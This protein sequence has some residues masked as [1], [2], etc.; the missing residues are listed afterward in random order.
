MR[1]PAARSLLPEAH[2]TGMQ[3]G[4]VRRYRAGQ[5]SAG[6]DVFAP[7]QEA[8]PGACQ[9]GT[10]PSLRC[11]GLK[12]EADCLASSL[13]KAFSFHPAGNKEMS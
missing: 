3:A 4:T 10:L 5:A 11:S 12:E 7:A 2:P 1:M 9:W 8:L 13:Q 6:D